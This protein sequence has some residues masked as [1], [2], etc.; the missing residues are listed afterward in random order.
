M[1]LLAASVALLLDF[2]FRFSLCSGFDFLSFFPTSLFLSI[3]TVELDYRCEKS[4]KH[5]VKFCPGEGNILFL[6]ACAIPIIFNTHMCVYIY[7]YIYIYCFSHHLNLY[8]YRFPN[9]GTLFVN[10]Q[11]QILYSVIRIKYAGIL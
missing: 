8:D 2:M 4:R 9:T 5:L 1:Y 6:L 3:Q 10:T 11:V 7:I